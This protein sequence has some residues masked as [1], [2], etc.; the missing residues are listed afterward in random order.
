MILWSFIFLLRRQSVLGNVTGLPRAV[1]NLN[2]PPIV[3]WRRGVSFVGAAARAAISIKPNGE[4][5]GK[6]K[7]TLLPLP[8]G[9]LAGAASGRHYT[10]ME[11]KLAAGETLLLYTDGMTEAENPAGAQ[12]SERGCLAWLEQ[13]GA[14]PL[15]ALLDSLYAQVVGHSGSVQPADDCT[16]LAVRRLGADR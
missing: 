16:M 7:A 13:A 3:T 2:P 11:R 5:S 15:P 1:V 6:R 14:S 10:S 8:N 9:M 4:Y 12:F